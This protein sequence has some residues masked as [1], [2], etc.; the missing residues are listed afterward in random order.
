MAILRIDEWV[1]DTACRQVLEQFG[2]EG[3]PILFVNISGQHFGQ[4]GR[5]LDLVTDVLEGTHDPQSL[6]L[7]IAG[8][9]ASREYGDSKIA[10]SELRNL[11]VRIA[12][13]DFG[14]GY[15]SLTY[16]HIFLLIS[17]NPEHIDGGLKQSRES[18]R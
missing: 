14:Q 3:H 18:D 4:H 2:E 15:S 8:N 9:R 7:E 6:V 5:L 1:L 16:W 13:D 12:L 17:E 11:G 10:L